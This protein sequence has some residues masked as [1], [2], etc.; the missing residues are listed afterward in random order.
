[1]ERDGITW[2]AIEQILQALAPLATGGS[3]LVSA[4]I[5]MP[6]SLVQLV[7][8]LPRPRKSH[9][10]IPVPPIIGLSWGSGLDPI[11][12]LSISFI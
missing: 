9:V 7:A 10:Q 8:Q 11:A 4:T 6:D 3:K 12:P 2:V 1:M 5:F